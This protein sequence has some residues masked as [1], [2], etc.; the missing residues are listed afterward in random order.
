MLSSDERP[1]DLGFKTIYEENVDMLLRVALRISNSTEAAEDIVHDAFGKLV[2]KKLVFPSGNDAKYWLIRVV[3]NAAI[4]YAKRKGRE[5]RAYEKWWRS[6]ASPV[7][8]VEAGALTIK[9]TG[10][11]AGIQPSVEEDVLRGETARELR[12]C[13]NLLPEKLREVLVLK[14]YGGMNYKEIGK[15]LGISEGNVKVRA[16]RAREALLKRMKGEDSHVS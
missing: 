16:F 7:E 14:E 3:K 5:T 15:V 10:T 12:R 9:E 8:N 11:E 1:D 2:E 4:N 13:L 6:E